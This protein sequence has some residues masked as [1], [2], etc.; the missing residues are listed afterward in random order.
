ML[1][2]GSVQLDIW[3]ERPTFDVPFNVKKRVHSFWILQVVCTAALHRGWRSAVLFLRCT[4]IVSVSRLRSAA[5]VL[6]MANER[7]AVC[8]WV[9]EEV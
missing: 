1:H 5:Y 9:C 3:Y 2:T 8:W 6:R 4:F 7:L